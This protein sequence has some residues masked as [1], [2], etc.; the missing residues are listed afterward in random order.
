R[1]FPRYFFQSHQRTA[2]ICTGT[3]FR[4]RPESTRQQCALVRARSCY[5]MYIYETSG[6]RFR[7]T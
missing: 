3:Q 7:P 4:T 1:R 5:F 6:A 2:P